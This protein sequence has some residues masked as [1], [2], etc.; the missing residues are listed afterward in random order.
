MDFFT[1]AVVVAG[2]A[3]GAVVL[4]PVALGAVGFT[5][6]GIAA[7]SIAAKVM[8]LLALANGGGV[9]AGSWFSFWQS[10]G[11]AGLSVAAKAVVAG[12]GAAVGW[13][14]LT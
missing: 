7:G 10:V 14:A 8:S 5:S 9:A 3:V 2:G 6:A 11:A 1:A 12:V 4:A 13:L